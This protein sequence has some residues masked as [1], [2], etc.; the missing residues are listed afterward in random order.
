MSRH[1]GVERADGL[2]TPR[3]CGCDSAKSTSSGRIE[4]H[5][6]DG[7]Y[8]RVDQAVKRPRSACFGS[9]AELREG[10]RADA[11]LRGPVFQQTSRN[12]ALATEG[13]THRVP[14][15]HV[16]RHQANGSRTS[17]TPCCFG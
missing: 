10:D 7:F 9:V 16:R 4:G 17:P 5:N 8:E 6:L 11:E 2:P 3:Q 14:V 15:E 13:E 1:E 12:P